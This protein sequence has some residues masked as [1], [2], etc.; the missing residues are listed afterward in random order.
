M[1]CRLSAAL[2]ATKSFIVDLCRHH[3][4]RLSAAPVLR[5]SELLPKVLLS[6]YAVTVAVSPVLDAR[7]LPTLQ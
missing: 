2:V 3:V 1:L 4:G 6:S 5:Q 7:A